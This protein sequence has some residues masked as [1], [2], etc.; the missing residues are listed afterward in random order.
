M[1]KI[2]WDLEKFSK[3]RVMLPT[4][5]VSE[6]LRYAPDTVWDLEN[7]FENFQKVGRVIVSQFQLL[8]INFEIFEKKISDT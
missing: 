5:S 7:F 6:A 2:F 4:Q 1:E 3:F 8:W